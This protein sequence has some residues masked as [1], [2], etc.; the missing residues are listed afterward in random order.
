M[1]QLL[2]YLLQGYT[3]VCHSFFP[4]LKGLA[5]IF[6]FGCAGML[7]NVYAESVD[8]TDNQE[9]TA[10]VF[11]PYAVLATD[12]FSNVSG[13][14]ETGT[15]VFGLLEV[16]VDA[17]LSGFTGLSGF[18]AHISG[19]WAGGEDPSVNVGD[20]NTLSN[21]AAPD[22]TYLYEVWVQKY[23]MDKK[24]R[25]KLGLTTIDAD[26]MISEYG[27]M[28]INS[29]FGILPTFSG[30]TAVP[31]FPLSG[32]GALAQYSFTE[33]SY[34]QLGVYDGDAGADDE[35]GMDWDYGSDEGAAFVYEIGT[36][37]VF[38]GDLNGTYKFGGMYHT[39][40]FA[41]FRDGSTDHGNYN[42]Y[43]VADQVLLNQ[44][45]GDPK[46]AGF[47]RASY[48]PEEEINT[49]NFYVETGIN[50]FSPFSGRDDDIFGVG[51]LYTDFSD[52]AVRDLQLTEAHVNDSESV[53]EV[54]YQAQIT[55]W[56][57][58]KPEVQFIFDPMLAEDDAVL[59]GARIEVAF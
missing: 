34:L 57:V 11:T 59:F 54:F 53:L 19:L 45:A 31:T 41:D 55:P 52:D 3:W 4:P 1:H 32:L 46:L 18:S 50:L 37:K 58:V 28:F 44:V 10:Q 8:I 42:F 16:G 25:I 48:S 12:I 29:G 15:S 33:S 22:S 7:T 5:G 43:V 38:Q 21:L 47:F 6:L 36:E 49:V 24:L 23:F 20:F 13:G 30:N 17:D 39:G 35:H 2:K 51:L 26:F 9:S 40:E 27:S 14:Q 56:L